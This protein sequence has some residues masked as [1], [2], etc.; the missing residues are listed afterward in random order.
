VKKIREYLVQNNK[1]AIPEIFITG[2][3]KEDVYQEALKLNAAGYVEKPFDIK[4]LVE[5]V[6]DTL[7]TQN[8]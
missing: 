3:A 8:Y 7:S 2:Y 4:T 6:K 1:S 5:T